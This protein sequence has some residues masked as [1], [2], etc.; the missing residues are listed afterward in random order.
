MKWL[1]QKHSYFRVLPFLLV[2][3]MAKEKEKKTQAKLRVVRRMLM[4]T[5]TKKRK[6]ETKVVVLLA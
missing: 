6:M 3:M 2:R 5:V 1:P 4:R